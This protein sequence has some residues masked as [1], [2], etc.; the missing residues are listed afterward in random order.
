MGKRKKVKPSGWHEKT[1]VC[2]QLLTACARLTTAI[3]VLIHTVNNW[4]L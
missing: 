4:P 3:S 1:A 2:L